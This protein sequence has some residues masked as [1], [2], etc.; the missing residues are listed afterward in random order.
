MAGYFSVSNIEIRPSFGA[1][2]S[3][4]TSTLK[5]SPLFGSG[6][7]TFDT[8]WLQN[9]PKEVN[10]SDFWNLNFPHGFGLMPTFIAT[11]GIIGTLAWLLFFIFYLQLGLRA[12]FT[13]I[14]DRLSR[15]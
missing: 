8:D 12:I 5:S 14:S 15:F 9:K 11:T 10:Q 1:T 3:I 6:P 7:N 13:P 4:I 2:R